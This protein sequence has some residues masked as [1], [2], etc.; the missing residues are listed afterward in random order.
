MRQTEISVE[1]G[2]E[3]LKTQKQDRPAET[4]EKWESVHED[5]KSFFN[6]APKESV[7]SMLRVWHD[8]RVGGF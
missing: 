7:I 1:K 6:Q 4:W 8:L 3:F 5:L 2:L